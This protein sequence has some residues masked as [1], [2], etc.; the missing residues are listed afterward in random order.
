M[1]EEIDSDSVTNFVKE[2]EKY[3]F[4]G[5]EDYSRKRRFETPIE[6]PVTEYP[7]YAEPTEPTEESTEELG[8][9]P[10]KPNSIEKGEEEKEGETVTLKTGDLEKIIETAVKKALKTTGSIKGSVSGTPKKRKRRK[11]RE[12]KQRRTLHADVRNG[13]AAN[14][15]FLCQGYYCGP[16]GGVRFGSHW[17]VH[18]K[19]AWSLGGE[20]TIENLEALCE[21]CHCKITQRESPWMRLDRDLQEASEGRER[22]CIYCKEIFAN[23]F[24]KSHREHC[25]GWQDVPFSVDYNIRHHIR[26]L[27]EQ[28]SEES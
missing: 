14:Q 23:R 3:R 24:L 13:V 6:H 19:Y 7:K 8:A 17:E 12:V 22:V 25:K 11:K 5:G 4:K 20:D 27:R 10:I 9:K 21:K 26:E 16:K 1:S 2:L 28:D 18:H 15:D